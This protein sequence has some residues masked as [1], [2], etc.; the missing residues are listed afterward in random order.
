MARSHSRS[1]G[2]A[3]EPLHVLGRLI[4]QARSLI[5]AQRARVE[6]A[7]ALQRSMLPA[8]LPRV[9]GL[10]IA[11]RYV[12]SRGGLEVGGDWYDV[13]GM[14][15]GTVAIVIGDVE[16]HDVEAIAFMGQVRLSLRAAA[17]T[18]SDPGQVLAHSNDLLLSMGSTLFATCCFARFAPG[19]GELSLASAG[20]LPAIW[21][22]PRGHPYLLLDAAGMPLGVSTGQRYAVTHRW[23]TQEGA[24]VLLTDGV[25]EGPAFPLEEGLARVGRLAGAGCA[26][27]ADALA[28]KVIDVAELTGHVDDAAVLVIRYDGLPA[29]A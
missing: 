2:A 5:E 22:T 8:E 27:D 23:L 29:R 13:F 7:E 1:R 28:A 14:A 12:P 20:H 24:L 4:E 16:G 25:V 9:P 3:D 6:L 21:A 17:T 11:A 10:G 18:T 19:T 26:A 15:D